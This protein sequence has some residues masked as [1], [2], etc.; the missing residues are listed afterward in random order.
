MEDR[1]DL[2]D[3][4]LDGLDDAERE[5]VVR[6]IRD[7]HRCRLEHLRSTAPAVGD[8]PAAALPCRGRR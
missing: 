5:H 2:S 6:T 4:L 3:I 7:A 1:S 8:R